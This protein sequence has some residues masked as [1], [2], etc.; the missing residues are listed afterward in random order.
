MDHPL[1]ECRTCGNSRPI[2]DDPDHVVYECHCNAPSPQ[3]VIANPDFTFKPQLVWPT[4]QPTNACGDWKP[5]PYQR[6]QSC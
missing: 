4:L 3:L 2:T 1:D 5:L 6:N